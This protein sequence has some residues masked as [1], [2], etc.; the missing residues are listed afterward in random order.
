[1]TEACKLNDHFGVFVDQEPAPRATFLDIQAAKAWADHF[2]GNARIYPVGYGRIEPLAWN[3]YMAWTAE[4][5]KYPEAGQTTLVALNYAAL[6]LASET[7]ELVVVVDDK[8]PSAVILD[9]AGDV[10]WALARCFTESA[11]LPLPSWHLDRCFVQRLVHWAAKAVGK[12]KTAQRCGD[13]DRR[14]TDPV[15]RADLAETLTAV[16]VHLQSFLRSHGL[17]LE[18][19]CGRNK[20][21]LL[22]R[23]AQGT[24][25]ERPP[26]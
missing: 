2:A 14:L 13:F 1:M 11:L 15:W 18:T 21:K 23:L 10:A 6:E 22:A 17:D 25:N 7:M 26:T 5:A 20:A 4:T 24:L 12:I 3:D 16:L 9:E 8:A 19:A